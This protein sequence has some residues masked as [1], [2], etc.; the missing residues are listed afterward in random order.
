MT[1]F[2]I[3]F[4]IKEICKFCDLN[5]FVCHN[6]DDVI[7]QKIKTMNLLFYFHK[8]GLLQSKIVLSDNKFFTMQN[9]Y[10][11]FC[12]KHPISY[13]NLNI[14]C[15][16]LGELVLSISDCQTHE[17]VIFV[18]ND[19][20]FPIEITRFHL[21]NNI[22]NH[23][24]LYYVKI[25]NRQQLLPSHL[26]AITKRFNITS[27]ELDLVYELII[28]NYHRIITLHNDFFD[29]LNSIKYTDDDERDDEMKDEQKIIDLFKKLD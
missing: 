3:S 20:V 2:K 5:F 4:V 21:D 12:D 16:N 27:L 26:P 1:V 24:F 6:E 10:N 13:I 14:N 23:R 19:I 25:N 7:Q 15:E 18:K 17:L 9:C 28:Y 22:D 29:S 11:L 8:N